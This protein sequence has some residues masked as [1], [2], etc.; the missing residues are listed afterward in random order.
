M[1]SKKASQGNKFVRIISIPGRA[2]SKARDFYVKSMN[3]YA[4]RISCGPVPSAS[5]ITGLP[6]SFSARSYTDE[7]LR[8][9]VRVSSGRRSDDRADVDLHVGRHGPRAMPPRSSSVAMG[10]IDE[11]RPCCYF[12][13]DHVDTNLVFTAKS[14][15]N[16]Y[17]RSKSHAVSARRISVF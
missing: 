2:L 10:R 16:R 1:K 7:D 3:G 9:L 14:E 5:Q 17:P 4:D 15:I 13:E 12:S 6:K 11:E 8:E